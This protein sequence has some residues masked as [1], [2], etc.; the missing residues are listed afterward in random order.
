MWHHDP[1]HRTHQILT[2][3]CL[4]ETHHRPGVQ[5]HP[6]QHTHT[7]FK[8]CQ[9]PRLSAHRCLNIWQPLH[10]MPPSSCAHQKRHAGCQTAKLLSTLHK[11]RLCRLHTSF[12]VCF[13]VQRAAVPFAFHLTATATST[14]LP[15]EWT[16]GATGL[17]MC[18]CKQQAAM[19][20]VSI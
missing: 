6:S 1:Q 14:P 4:S 3:K 5:G 9:N 2:H 18:S 8:V 11:N 7:S 13:K 12:K 16:A 15:T 20:D 10:V 19:C 17:Y